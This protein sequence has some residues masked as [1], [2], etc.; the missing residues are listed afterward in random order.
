MSALLFIGVVI[1]TTI[2]KAGTVLPFGQVY[3]YR[4]NYSP[5][6]GLKI[7]D[8]YMIEMFK[9][10]YLKPRS[11]PL[12]TR[13]YSNVFRARFDNAGLSVPVCYTGLYL[14]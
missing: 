10:Q 14:I 13:L 3:S 5:P 7:K 12:P 1:Y 6:S 9:P 4:F 2:A 8:L 11:C